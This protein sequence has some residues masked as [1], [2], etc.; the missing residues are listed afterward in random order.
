MQKKGGE[1]GQKE[2]RHKISQVNRHTSDMEI[3]SYCFSFFVFLIL[4]N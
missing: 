4:Y 2:Q 1:G 3:E